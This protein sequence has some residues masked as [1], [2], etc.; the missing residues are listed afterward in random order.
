MAGRTNA[1]KSSLINHLLRHDNIARSSSNAGK[2][3][4]IELYMVNDKIIIADFP[5]FGF[6]VPGHQ[7]ISHL[8]ERWEDVWQPLCRA[9]IRHAP[10]CAALFLADVRWPVTEDD[11]DFASMLQAAELPALLIM[12]KDDRINDKTEVKGHGRL[13]HESWQATAPRHIRASEPHHAREYLA[14]RVRAGLSWPEHYPHLHYS[15]EQSPPRRKLRRWIASFAQHGTKEAPSPPHRDP[16]AP[17]PEREA[18]R[19]VH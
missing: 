5:G 10:V 15:N 6:T 7:Y 17:A 16:R 4:A 11:R 3:D 14:R 1:G 13:P 19:A 18:P 2:T 9:Y 8:A 12:T